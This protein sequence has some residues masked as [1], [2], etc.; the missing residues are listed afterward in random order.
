MMSTIT[1]HSQAEILALMDGVPVAAIATIAGDKM[2]NRMM[3][4]AADEN[5]NIYLA[6]M[7]GDP[8]TI[9]MTNQPSVAL[10]IHQSGMDINNSKEVEITGKAIFVRDPQEREHALQMTAKRSPVVKYMTES[11]NSSP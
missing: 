4:Y 5:F 11:G 9:Q 10:L 8:K 2:R 7:K 6:S 1:Q 3:H